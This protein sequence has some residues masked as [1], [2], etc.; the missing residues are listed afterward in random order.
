MLRDG[1]LHDGVCEVESTGVFQLVWINAREQ[2][3][4]EDAVALTTLVLKPPES[5]REVGSTRRVLPVGVVERRHVTGAR[6]A[7][8]CRI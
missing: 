5:A 4:A 3:E 8:T 7:L 2:H 6:V 1:S